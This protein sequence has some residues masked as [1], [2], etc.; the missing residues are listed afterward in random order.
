MAMAFVV[1]ALSAAYYG[2]SV[3]LVVWMQG[4]G[5]TGHGDF[6]TQ[7]QL[8]T[9]SSIIIWITSLGVGAVSILTWMLS[10]GFRSVSGSPFPLLLSSQKSILC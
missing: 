1:F 6:R 7:D 5:G 9:A 2:Y 8:A 4:L 3:N 10:S